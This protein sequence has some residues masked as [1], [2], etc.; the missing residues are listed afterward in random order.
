MELNL[1]INVIKDSAFEGCDGLIDSLQL[2]NSL[3][4]IGNKAFKDCCNIDGVLNLPLSVESIGT[5]SFEN[6]RISSII[7][8]KNIKSIGKEAFVNSKHMRVIDFSSFSDCPSQDELSIGDDAFDFD[9]EHTGTVYI[10]D[11]DDISD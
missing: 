9:S 7:F 4:N 11:E 2:P 3:I 5:N 6:T 8:G 10:H 1:G